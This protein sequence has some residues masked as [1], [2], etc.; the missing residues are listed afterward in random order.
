[1]DIWKAARLTEGTRTVEANSHAVSLS[2]SRQEKCLHAARAYLAPHLCEDGDF[3]LLDEIL[4]WSPSSMSLSSR[5]AP[6]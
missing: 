5:H 1:M 2:E 6:V 4:Q 3:A